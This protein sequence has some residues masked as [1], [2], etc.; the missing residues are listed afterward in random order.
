MRVLAARDGSGHV[1]LF[2]GR[3]ASD[4]LVVASSRAVLEGCHDV[5]EFQPGACR[6]VLGRAWFLCHGECAVCAEACVQ[7]V[8]SPAQLCMQ[9][10]VL[11]GGWG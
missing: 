4:S 3:T 2:E 6:A 10:R 11:V 1:P 5:V 8:G 7:R 9:L